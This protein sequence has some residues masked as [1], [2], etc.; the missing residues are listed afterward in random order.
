[1]R[2]YVT[3]VVAAF[4]AVGTTEVRAWEGN[5]ITA[6]DASNVQ[7][8]LAAG[9]VLA[10]QRYV[11][12]T[13][14][15]YS[16]Q[17]VDTSDPIKARAE[18][19]NKM[20]R[21]VQQ[22]LVAASAIDAVSSARAH[23]ALEPLVEEAK[24]EKK[25][26]D[27]DVAFMGLNWGLGFGY[28][29]SQDDAIDDAE[30]VNG[31]VRI[32]TEKKEQPRVVL[33][34]H[35]YFWCASRDSGTASGCGPYVAVSA[36]ADELLSGVGMGFMYGRK[37]KIDDS[38]G[39]SVGIGVILDGKVKDLGEGFVANEAPPEGE[40]AVRFEEKSRWSALLFVSRT[41]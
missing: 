32:K 2:I 35:K 1:M 41:F 36:T 33:E 17:S 7:S 38:E 4:L 15:D 3:G 14:K 20:L 37:A 11:Q 13:C 31:I 25:E 10:A 6:A 27:S 39:F 19:A 28:S 24:Q 34:F 29:F 12:T 18:K 21:C 22:T 8:A 26:A 9:N 40:T 23:E 5:S 30:I 16:D